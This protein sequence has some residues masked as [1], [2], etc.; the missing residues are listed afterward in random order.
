MKIKKVEI[1][2]F[3]A[4]KSKSD[5][6][7]DF[8]AEGN[9]PANFVAIYAPNGFGK[10]SF[11]DAVEWAVTNHLERLGGDYNKA[12][13]LS[14]AKSSKSPDE[15]LK[16]LRN[17]YADDS[18]DT[19]V[20]VS[21]NS[22]ST[23]E[24]KLPKIRKNQMDIR[25][26]DDGKREND[27]FRRVILSQDEIDRFL[28]EAKPQERYSKFMKSFGGDLDV[29][30]Q[31]LA[32]LINDNL[33]ELSSLNKQHNSLEEKLRQPIDA[34]IFEQFNTIAAELNSQG[35][36]IILPDENISSQEIHLLNSNLVA[37]RHELNTSQEAASKAIETLSEHSGQIP[38]IKLHVSSQAEHRAKLSWLS[39]ALA[40]ADTYQGLYKSYEKYTE[41]QKQA[42]IQLELITEISEKVEYFLQIE[43]SLKGV[44]NSKN[45]LINECSELSSNLAGLKTN[46]SE[47]ENGI[48]QNETKA[49]QLGSL[50]E[51]SELVYTELKDNGIQRA[52]LNEEI[53]NKQVEV[54]SNKAQQDKLSNELEELAA[55]NVT[56]SFLIAGNL[57]PLIFGKEKIERITK[58]HTD[59][60]LLK[61]HEQALKTTQ[62]ALSEQMGVHE[63]LI[64]IGI[65]FLHME[66]S[67]TCPLCNASH[68]S[69][70]ELIGKI[71]NQNLHSELSQENTNKINESLF[72][73]KQ[74]NDEIQQITQQALEAQALQLSTLRNKYN[75]VVSKLTKSTQEKAVFED[76]LRK[77]EFRN[78]ELTESVWGLSKQE[79]STKVEVELNLLSE[80]RVGLESQLNSLTEKINDANQSL[81]SKRVEQSKLESEMS[82]KTNDHI[83]AYV[84]NYLNENAIATQDIRSHCEAKRNELEETFKGIKNS[85]D[86][87]IIQCN[88]LQNKMMADGTWVNVSSLKSEKESLDIAVANSQSKINAYYDSLASRISI[89]YEDSL[90]QVQLLITAKA[91]EY[92]G[93]LKDVEKV[94]NGVNLL[95]ELMNSFKP[96]IEHLSIQKELE[97][98]ELQ[99][100][101]RQQVDAMLNAE[102][103]IIIG[104]LQTLINNFFFEDLINS[105]YRKIDPHPTF[106]KVEFKVNFGTD[107]GIEKPSLDILVSDGEGGMISPILYFSAAQTNILSLSVFLANALH[108]K[109]D[110]GNPIDV[111]L[112]DDPIQS[113]DSINVLSTIDLLR[114]ICLKFGKQIIISTHD[115]NFFGL[116]Q[117]KIP[118]EVFGSKFLR[119]ERFGVVTPVAPIFSE[120]T[121]QNNVT[122]E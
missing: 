16:I 18:V 61:V 27:F 7:F 42:S 71:K 111:I 102:K 36:K 79:L 84:R 31:E 3:R 85:S 21:T 87:L 41:D 2:A 49:S 37:R 29:A 11:Y 48:K 12:N 104:K 39:N 15:G 19:K 10:S 101:Q 5:G 70:D 56:S 32:V 53:I 78:N 14:A 55:L 95:L 73:Q 116:L 99:L 103:S 20:I 120:K 107:K 69:P 100:A 119:L 50:K 25:I 113:M 58:C 33:S 114:S 88:D 45:N 115:E 72:L 59:V 1:E 22:Q 52:K 82:T 90:E 51:S 80:A 24:R 77:L 94:L 75:D 43:S 40:D 65:E 30:R 23:F 13:N 110:K 93:Q 6:T 46:L 17:K 47:L 9:D 8:T 98:V 66:P 74:L 97:S 122:L 108:A 96:Y 112:V 118:S 117:R 76:E 86:S 106:K 35:E 64:S 26:G 105:I 63:Q 28:R 62:K 4:Y 91:E 38:E 81:I 67:S 92:R 83:Y 68:P 121:E 44:T 109:D 34:S 54:H 89:S 57:G 60:S